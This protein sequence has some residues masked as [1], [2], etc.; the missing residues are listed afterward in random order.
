[1]HKIRTTYKVSLEF[2]IGE[3]DLFLFRDPGEYTFIDV[4]KEGDRIH[5]LQLKC[6]APIRGTLECPIKIVCLREENRLH[7]PRTYILDL[8]HYEGYLKRI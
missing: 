7:E 3:P 5:L 6:L 1:M 8:D 2:E 4:K